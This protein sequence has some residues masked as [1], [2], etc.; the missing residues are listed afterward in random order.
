MEGNE[1]IVAIVAI[2]FGTAFT[3]FVLYLFFSSIK[4][5]I[6][7]KNSSLDEESFDRMAKAFIQH[8]KDTERRLEHLEAIATDGDELSGN[9]KELNTPQEKTIEI[10]NEEPQ[11]RKERSDSGNLRNILKE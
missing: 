5:W 1:F 4:S 6:G 8:K 2:V 9:H 7:R 10:E 3:A 11:K